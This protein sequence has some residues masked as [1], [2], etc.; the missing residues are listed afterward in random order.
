MGTRNL[1]AVYEGGAYRVAQYGQ[2]DGYPEGQGITVL[3]FLRDKMNEALFRERVHNAKYISPAAL[4]ALWQRYGADEHGYV[5]CE[6]ADRMKKDY[7][8]FSRDI[9]AEIL[10]LVQNSDNGILLNDRLGFAADSL[11]C[12][13]AW[14][15][16]LDGRTFEGF[17]GFNNMRLPD[18]ERFAFLN[19]DRELEYYPVRRVAKFSLDELPDDESFLAAFQSEEEENEEAEFSSVI[20]M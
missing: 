17:A 16:D 1:V 15:V 4:S 12:E 2:W 10:E 9:G 7:P 19:P 14:V 18:D 20:T 6:D 11:F 8:Q 5:R 13:W 3:Q